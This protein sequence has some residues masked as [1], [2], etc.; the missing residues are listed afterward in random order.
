M[1]LLQ[2]HLLHTASRVKVRVAKSTFLSGFPFTQA[3]G[4]TD[5]NNM[6]TLESG[7]IT[8]SFLLYYSIYL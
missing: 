1:T 8:D 7:G 2:T 4:P 6:E 3:H 5:M